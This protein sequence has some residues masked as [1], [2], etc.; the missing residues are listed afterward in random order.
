[1]VFGETRAP[2]GPHRLP[3]V[4]DEG[5]REDPEEPGEPGGHGQ[6]VDPFAPVSLGAGMAM[7]SG[8]IL[9]PVLIIEV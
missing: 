2:V 4:R 9:I 5:P 1:M 6:G 8:H 3:V 7:L